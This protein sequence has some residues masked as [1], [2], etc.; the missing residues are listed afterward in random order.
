M[1]LCAYIC[2][3]S[4]FKPI[5]VNKWLFPIADADDVYYFEED[6][7]PLS[8]I[9]RTKDGRCPALDDYPQQDM[10]EKCAFFSGSY[11]RF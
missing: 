11:Q 7:S 1:D 2:I 10:N 9:I 8:L 4:F 3:S 6:H 5:L